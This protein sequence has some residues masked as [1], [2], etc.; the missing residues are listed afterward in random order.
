MKPRKGIVLASFAQ[1]L[2]AGYVTV[3]LDTL[4][5][6][7]KEPAKTRR[8]EYSESQDCDTSLSQPHEMS[9]VAQTRDRL[10]T[11][12][13]QLTGVQRPWDTGRALLCPRPFTRPP[14]RR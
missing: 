14:V 8:Q 3:S 4:R 1:G 7:R 11:A 2:S 12:E 6:S 13:R 10:P 5:L 9:L